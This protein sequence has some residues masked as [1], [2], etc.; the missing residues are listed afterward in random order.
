MSHQ[1]ALCASVCLCA[2]LSPF[3]GLINDVT[4]LHVE[5]PVFILQGAICGFLCEKQTTHTDQQAVSITDT[6]KHT[7]DKTFNPGGATQRNKLIMSSSHM[8]VTAPGKIHTTLQCHQ[9]LM[10]SKL[11]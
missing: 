10:K 9:T 1:E 5:C 6:N 2:A 7:Q 11:Q 3:L 8:T 4:D